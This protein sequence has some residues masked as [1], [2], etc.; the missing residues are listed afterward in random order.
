MADFGIYHIYIYIWHGEAGRCLQNVRNNMQEQASSTHTSCKTL[1]PY[2][3]SAVHNV[4]WHKCEYQ[5]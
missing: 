4:I 5:M 1:M 2:L 3:I